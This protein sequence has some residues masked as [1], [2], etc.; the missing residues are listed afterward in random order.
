MIAYLIVGL[1]IVILGIA[2]ALFVASYRL[3]RQEKAVGA[4][5]ERDEF[6]MFVERVSLGVERID[7]N[8]Q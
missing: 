4:V 3:H 6:E 5:R 7:D 1:S 2:I 8:C